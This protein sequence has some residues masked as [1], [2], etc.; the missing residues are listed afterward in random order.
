MI[1]PSSLYYF[2]WLP[3][4]LQ[5]FPL[6]F[7]VRLL[8]GVPVQKT[9]LHKGEIAEVLETREHIRQVQVISDLERYH[10]RLWLPR[11][12][13]DRKR[14]SAEQTEGV[15]KL[16]RGETLYRQPCWTGEPRPVADT[17]ELLDVSPGIDAIENLRA[18]C[19]EYGFPFLRARDIVCLW[20]PEPRRSRAKPLDHYLPDS[21]VAR[22][23]LVI[24]DHA[25][26]AAMRKGV[27]E[28]VMHGM[29]PREAAKL[30]GESPKNLSK[31]ARRVVKEL[32]P[33]DKSAASSSG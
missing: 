8:T 4:H 21:E 22:I 10:K 12:A 17:R 7:A 6:R 32:F 33:P 2:P 18:I 23:Q 24:G 30:V 3:L 11:R 19:S 5:P 26:S 14:F 1:N 9:I 29:C 31:N 13:S 25:W 27:T 15:F 28:I 20:K 16:K